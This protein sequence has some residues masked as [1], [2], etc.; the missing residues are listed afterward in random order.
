[1]ER[2]TAY[3]Y[4]EILI[5]VLLASLVL[6]AQSAALCWALAHLPRRRV[7]YLLPEA[8][9]LAVVLLT[10]LLLG[11]AWKL[12]FAELPPTDWLAAERW[13]AGLLCL[14][15]GLTA[16]E[17]RLLPALLLAFAGLCSLPMMDAFLPMSAALVL[18]LLG[19]RLVLLA[20]RARARRTREVTIS[21]IRAGLDLLPVGIL[22]AREDHAAVLVNIAMLHFMERLFGRQYRNAAV[23]WQDLTAFDAPAVAEKW[24]REGAVLLRFAAGDVWLVQRVQLLGTLSGWQ[25]TAS[26]VTELD[27]VTQELREKN[28]ELSTTLSAQKELLQNLERT[29]R[30]RTLQEITSRVHDILGQRISMLQQLL[31]SPAPKDALRTI[32]RIDS[33]LE[34]VPLAQEPHPATL[35]ADMTDTYRSL[36][37]RLTLSGTLPRNMRRARAFAAII[38]EALSNAVCHGRANE[39]VIALSERRLHI[40][41]NG[42]GCT[43]KLRP[44]GGLTG[45]MR[46]VNALGG[47]LIITPAPHFELDAQIGEKQG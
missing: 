36:G 27:A 20:A 38:R 41:D 37:V 30:S 24:Q 3:S 9:A 23:F 42:I 14:V 25:L 6:I 39:I 12:F 33:L 13:T 19:V 22:F 11:G 10:T 16:C 32:V 8:A 28:E 34:S 15:V 21:S 1:M 26:C 45:M 43:G 31:A 5:L 40:R 7:C 29:E 44:G 17:R 4:G 46:R 18:L 47:R 35:L 2:L